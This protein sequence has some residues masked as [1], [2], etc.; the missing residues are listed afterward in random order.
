[1]TAA[2]R[3]TDPITFHG[4]GPYWDAR[5]ERLLFVDMFAGAV[6]SRDAGGAIARHEVP[7][8]IAAVVRRRASGGLV[9][10]TERDLLAADDALAA[11][12]PIARGLVGD[13]IRLN[14]GGCDAPGAFLIGSM[15]YDQTPGAASV[16]RIAPDGAVT[17]VLEAATISNGLQFS[18][19]GCTA[20]YVDTPTRRI[21]RVDVDPA[22][23]A[24]SGRRP[25]VAID[26]TPGSPD[27]LAIDVD[28]GLWVAL[29]D[30]GAVR[31]YD[32]AGALV[33]EIAV[34]GATRVT[35]CA[36]GDADRRTLYVTTSRENLADGEEPLAGS[37][38]AVRTDVAGAEPFAF[39]G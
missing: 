30:G 37:L 11:F 16:Q 17:T 3:L 32:A 38:Y 21:D 36:F 31:H 18:A 5:N 15:A 26:G 34:P 12:T 20:F 23:G 33:E 8:T 9:V 29:Y 22:T 1:M 39:A 24:W 10:A 6:V 13:G 4:E 28:G 27:G 35:A 2:E 25:H 19:D 7:S 14:E